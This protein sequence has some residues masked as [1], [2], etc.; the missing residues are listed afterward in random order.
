MQIVEVEWLDAHVSTS[1]TTIKAAQKTKPI[2]TLTVGYLIAETDE[3][4]TLVTDR[5]PDSPKEGKVVNH[6]PWGMISR[7]WYYG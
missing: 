5:Y 1:S 2:K 4:I 7:W 3:G 6:I